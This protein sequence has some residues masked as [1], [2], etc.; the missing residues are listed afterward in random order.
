MNNNNINKKPV[1]IYVRA[2]LFTIVEIA[3]F[4]FISSLIESIKDGFK[5][6]NIIQLIVDV[7]LFMLILFPIIFF[8][9]TEKSFEL[10]ILGTLFGLYLVNFVIL[11]VYYKK[12]Q[13]KHDLN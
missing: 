6:T 5:D 10:I 2:F 3:L 7:P 1:N 12:K 13:K 9:Y 8:N 4:I 11:S